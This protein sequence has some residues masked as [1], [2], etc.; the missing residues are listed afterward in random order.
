M[1]SRESAHRS[2][3]ER[4]AR[5][6]VPDALLPKRSQVHGSSLES[7]WTEYLTCF[8]SILAVGTQG[9]DVVQHPY[10]VSLDLHP[11]EAI[12]VFQPFNQHI[13]SDNILIFVAETTSTGSG[14][15]LII[16]IR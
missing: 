11:L 2:S 13:E 12:W 8:T 3:R 5:S 10:L 1:S 7:G 4:R 15:C 9:N 6:V 16:D 14:H